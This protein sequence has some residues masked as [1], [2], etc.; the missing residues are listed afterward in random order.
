MPDS[1]L[2]ALT[3]S[4]PGTAGLLYTV[5]GGA[6][7]KLAMTAAGAQMLEAA[8][9]AAQHA[10]LGA[11]AQTFSAAGATSVPAVKLSGAWK[12][13]TAATVAQM[14]LEDPTG[15]PTVFAGAA[16]GTGLGMNIKTFTGNYLDF[17]LNGLSQFSLSSS[18]LSFQ[19]VASSTHGLTIT[20]NGSGA[21]IQGLYNG[22]AV[23]RGSLSLNAGPTANAVTAIGVAG[24]PSF[25]IQSGNGAAAASLHGSFIGNSVYTFEVRP[26]H[27]DAWGAYTGAG[28]AMSITGG[29]ASV[30]TTGGAGGAL[31]LTGGAAGSAGAATDNNGGDVC[32]VGGAATGTGTIGALKF[33]TATSQLIGFWNVTPVTQRTGCAVPT[34]LATAITA[35]TALR[36]ALNELGLT[37]VV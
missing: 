20:C 4:T 8:N 21:I 17:Q 29:K 35:I 13:A 14:L 18:V 34:D 1:A 30:T 33:G 12:V 9:A 37:T 2:S 25:C 6:D 11:L 31:N 10:L 16:A 3:A 26:T 28:H 7:R 15:S 27:K 19:A 24:S 32:L 5:Q 22:S 36:T 23:S